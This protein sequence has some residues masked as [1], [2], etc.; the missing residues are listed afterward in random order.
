MENSLQRLNDIMK[1]YFDK[2]QEIEDNNNKLLSDKSE[3]KEIIQDLKNQRID[4]RKELEKQLEEVEKEQDELSIRAE[5]Y[6]KN[7][8]E[9]R[10]AEID[11]Y[12]TNALDSNSNFFVGY[13]SAIR[14]DLEKEYNKRIREVRDDFS[15]Q[16]D[17]LI[18]KESQLL[19]E[20]RELKYRQD[21]E[22]EQ[23]A[24]LEAL[25]NTSDFRNVDLREMAEV[26]WG[27]RKELYS[28]RK[29][30]DSQLQQEELNFKQAMLNLSNF[31]Y[32][33]N[34]QKMVINGQDWK[35]L[36]EESNKIS[37]RIQE[38][39]EALKKVDEYQNL[40]ETTPEENAAA[41]R[42]LTPWEKEEYERRKTI[43]S[44]EVEEEKVEVNESEEIPDFI[45]DNIP[46]NNPDVVKTLD[47]VKTPDYI[48]DTEGIVVDTTNDLLSLVF[49]EIMGEV[50]NLKSVRIN[51]SKGK[52]GKS[53]AYISVKAG[54]D[55]EYDLLNTTL[56][57][58]DEEGLELPNGEYINAEDFNK[59][60]EAYQS[61]NKGYTY[62]VKQTGKKYSTTDKSLQKF[63]D[64]LKKCS[65]L[66]LVR[67]SKLA[68]MD[69][70]SVFGKANTD[71]KY[72]EHQLSTIYGR[73]EMPEG[74][75]INK[76]DVITAMTSLLS[77][78]R[79]EWVKIVSEKLKSKI[80]NMR[81][82]RYLSK[83][84]KYNPYYGQD[85]YDYSQNFDD[86]Q[87][88]KK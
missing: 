74:E 87:I 76:F 21:D 44:V 50:N 47:V 37:D 77:K 22:K 67:K 48:Y 65:A 64:R 78:R 24:N 79:L 82:R 4:H 8:E 6:I 69:V 35:A 56:D 63:K 1:P 40:L 58:S 84:D 17:E 62:I 55:K 46:E 30:L 25:N 81:D 42:S 71:K 34:D 26:K 3:F 61:K 57:L 13:A 20:I 68:R 28:Y 80:D 52:L 70:V 88:I 11:E 5:K 15:R 51:P 49:N 29:E 12:V 38:I 23:I 85:G 73:K 43:K 27:L 32:E 53:E 7:L 18:F 86:D 14:R 59:A 72:R 54:F 39:R 33:Y 36:Y 45:E 41:M 16:N 19:Q 66:N 31:K 2:N 60:L 9:R 10:D 83:Y 75:Y